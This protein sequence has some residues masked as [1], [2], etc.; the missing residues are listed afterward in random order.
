MKK[1]V[2]RYEIKLSCWNELKHSKTTK[3]EEELI[4]SI[5]EHFTNNTSLISQIWKHVDS[6]RSER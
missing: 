5:D 1:V 3:K 6:P 4:D 2:T